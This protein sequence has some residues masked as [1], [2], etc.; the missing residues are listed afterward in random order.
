[1]ISTAERLIPLRSNRERQ[2]PFH[3]KPTL[4]QRSWAFSS[5]PTIDINHQTT[6]K[7][8]PDHHLNSSLSTPPRPNY[9]PYKDPYIDHQDPT[10]TYPLPFPVRE[11][12]GWFHAARV[13]SSGL[14]SSGWVAVALVT[15]EWVGGG[16]MGGGWIW[17][18]LRWM[19]RIYA[20]A[21]VSFS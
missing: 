17:G 13:L 1:M 6:M 11:V 21:E 5:D 9:K 20:V 14:L 4:S 12:D 2:T 3:V 16:G 15:V 10:P 19:G 7:S 8:L 18:S